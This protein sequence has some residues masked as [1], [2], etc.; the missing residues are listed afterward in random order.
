MDY[1]N[2]ISVTVFLILVLPIALIF[3]N[4]Q[5]TIYQA[6]RAGEEPLEEDDEGWRGIA[7]RK[8]GLRLRKF[9]FAYL[10][11]AC[12][13]YGGVALK[14]PAQILYDGYHPSPTP[15]MTLTPRPTR[16]PYSTPTPLEPA[17][18]AEPLTVQVPFAVT[19][20]VTPTA[21]ELSP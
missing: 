8:R 18:T 16:T 14:K 19:V 9:L 11:A 12:L 17:S 4:N 5:Q 21:T 1:Y 6:V 10:V 20:V 13:L 3:V 15:T 7:R 2:A